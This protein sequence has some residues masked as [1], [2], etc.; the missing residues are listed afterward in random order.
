MTSATVDA[1]TGLQGVLI[2]KDE[3]IKRVVADGT[4]K[5]ILTHRQVIRGGRYGRRHLLVV[6]HGIGSTLGDFIFARTGILEVVFQNGH[7][8]AL[9][10]FSNLFSRPAVTHGDSL[11]SKIGVGIKCIGRIDAFSGTK[12]LVMRPS[13]HAIGGDNLLDVGDLKFS[14]G[15]GF[16]AV[17]LSGFSGVVLISVEVSIGG[18]FFSG[19]KLYKMSV[20]TVSPNKT[21]L[22]ER[23]HQFGHGPACSRISILHLSQ[24]VGHVS[25]VVEESGCSHFILRRIIKVVLF[26]H[27]GPM[28]REERL[29]SSP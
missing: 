2:I 12:L 28:P 16:Y 26:R 6:R 10:G 29:D 5:R 21:I 1:V 23:V 15:F 13:I 27:P 25:F 3:G 19:T 9:N 22:R 20:G 18:Y 17:K 11:G 4:G 24:L 8:V 7:T 14:H